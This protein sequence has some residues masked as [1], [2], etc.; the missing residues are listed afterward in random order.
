ML[1]LIVRVRGSKP[2]PH[3]VFMLLTSL[4][5]SAACTR[6]ATLASHPGSALARQAPSIP[7]VSTLVSGSSATSIAAVPPQVSVA[8]LSA[9]PV[10]TAS[11]ASEAYD[12]DAD[13]ATR[14]QDAREQLGPGASALRVTPVFLLA[15]PNAGATSGARPFIDAVLAAYMNGRFGRG[16]ERAITIFMF[17]QVAQFHAFCRKRSGANCISEFGFYEPS[18]RV[19]IMNG[20][21]NGT[22]SHELAHPFVE[23][24]FPSAPTWLN[25]GIASLYEQPNL[26]K[27]GEIHG[28]KNWRLPRLKQAI[29]GN[30][31]LKAIVRLEAIMA[32]TEETFR[33][34]NESLHYASARY[35]CQWLDERGWLWEFYHAYRDGF[36]DDP[37][38]VKSFTKVVGAS[39]S[40]S[41]EAWLKWIRN[42]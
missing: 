33:D 42:L 29:S 35:M 22:L 14:L 24:D 37:T 11:S 4:V 18:G 40:E 39:P 7:N 12:L 30:P 21:A 36:A 34:E 1:P 17:P 13:V 25:E 28:G 23:A 9:A 31:A 26:V 38:G 27:K 41:T 15:G 6:A 20:G 16:P 5:I 8:G 3:L 32:L 2:L 19:I 10:T